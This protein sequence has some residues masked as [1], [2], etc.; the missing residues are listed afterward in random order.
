M[1]RRARA[2]LLLAVAVG[3][4]LVVLAGRSFRLAQR[5]ST[6]TA[7][8]ARD[9]M[10]LLG[11][12]PFYRAALHRDAIR[13]A[14][15]DADGALRLTIDLRALAGTRLGEHGWGR[16][17]EALPPSAEGEIRLASSPADSAVIAEDNW[18]VEGTALFDLL[19]RDAGSAAESPVWRAVPGEP[20]AVAAV[21][22]VPAR[23]SESEFGGPALADWRARADIAEKVLGRPLR[24]ALAQDLGGLAVFALYE[25]VSGREPDALLA[26]ELKRSDRLRSL[27]DTVFA[28]GALTERATIQRYREIPI[29]TIRSQ[30]AGT[31]WAVAID[32]DV[33]VIARSG[34]LVQ[35][36]IDAHRTP[37]A[38]T[39]LLA[40]A[41][42]LGTSWCAV[43]DS[44]F[45]AHGWARLAREGAG[46][47]GGITKAEASLI[48]EGASAWRLTGH[49]PAA[50]ITAD[51]VVP[52]VRGL[53]AP[54][55][56]GA[57]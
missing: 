45:V 51:P 40:R 34:R 36:S 14:A 24:A 16:I 35:A 49:G 17:E 31:G 55:H 30:V 19:D 12:T 48:P 4:V 25:P 11:R 28:L 23:I 2:T 39:P 10:D 8:M 44:A 20:S 50:A 7:A 42:T 37:R 1:T 43:S 27:F 9:A 41:G 47:A 33:L 22:I 3:A 26:V 46:S 53:L 54:A 18:T 29:G 6:G 52:F 38:P 15:R 21:R 32:G 13:R 5:G 56:R 57:D